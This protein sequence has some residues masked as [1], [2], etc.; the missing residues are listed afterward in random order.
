MKPVQ[1]FQSKLFSSRFVQSLTAGILSGL[2]LTLAT[3]PI[4]WGFCALIALVPLFLRLGSNPKGWWFTGWVFSMTYH[5][6][7]IHWIGENTGTTPWLAFGS[8]IAMTLYLTLRFS[9]LFLL[10][11]WVA[12]RK[13]ARIGLLFLVVAWGGFEWLLSIG[14]LGFPWTIGILPLLPLG[15]PLRLVSVGGL[16]LAG[17]YLVAV[18]FLIYL[19]WTQKDWRK[20]TATVVFILSPLALPITA[21]VKTNLVRVG[22]VQPNIDPA[23]K[24]ANDPFYTIDQ[25]IKLSRELLPKHPDFIIWPETAVPF[26]LQAREGH[27]ERLQI[28]IDQ[29][30]VPIVTG[31][32]HYTGFGDDIQSYN[33][34][35]VIRP[36]R[37]G[38][39]DP[40]FY[41]KRW[42]VPMG[43]RIPFQSIIP[44]LHGIELGQAEFAEGPREKPL[45]VPTRFGEVKIGTPVCYESIFPQMASMF[46]KND[47][48]LLANVTND[49]WYDGTMEKSQH[50]ELFRARAL[51]IGVP[52]VRSANTGIS[53][54]ID[55][56]GQWQAKMS[57]ATATSEVYVIPIPEHPAPGL[58]STPWWGYLC[59]VGTF[60][61]GIIP[62][63]RYPAW[64]RPKVN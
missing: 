22:V 28:L 63:S 38:G 19:S 50:A 27:R 17:T 3:P 55:Y 64:L 1:S 37:L 18:N 60:A 12:V 51:E 57:E 9:I 21:P 16:W 49:G 53:G 52:L 26:Y 14:E 30:D 34:V 25:A 36:S 24:W 56:R 23:G 54:W 47:V 15:F 39:I 35:F 40:A 42:L 61:I 46:A 33:A 32:Q 45:P 6:I 48:Q 7:A 13:G 44:Q 4:G 11:G 20:A 8:Y 41:A 59:I 5:L 43:E 58:G 2:L 10:A 29:L 62:L 31:A